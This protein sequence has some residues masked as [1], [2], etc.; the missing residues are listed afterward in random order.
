MPPSPSTDKPTDVR[1]QAILP[2]DLGIEPALGSARLERYAHNRAKS[3]G[4]DGHW[5]AGNKAE[6]R[7]RMHRLEVARR[8]AIA[9]EEMQGRLPGSDGDISAMRVDRHERCIGRGCALLLDLEISIQ[10]KQARN[11]PARR[12]E[13]SGCRHR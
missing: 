1:E 4:T 11:P 10:Q 8:T 9:V 12:A 7:Q 2:D 13:R 3:G 6:M 5:S